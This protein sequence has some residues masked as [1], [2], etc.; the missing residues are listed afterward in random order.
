MP[1]KPVFID[2]C[3]SQVDYHKP[4]RDAGCDVSHLPPHLRNVGIKDEKIMEDYGAS[5]IIV[6][7]DKTFHSGKPPKTPL[8]GVVIIAKPHE[9]SDLKKYKSRIS[10]EFKHNYGDYPGKVTVL[11]EEDNEVLVQRL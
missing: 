5:N 3:V 9:V 8:K 11:G 7:H 2:N 6:T 1:N 10:S 4:F